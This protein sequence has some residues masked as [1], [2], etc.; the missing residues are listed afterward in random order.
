MKSD[1]NLLYKRREKKYSGKKLASFLIVVLFFAGSLYAGIAIPSQ[2]LASAKLELA[3]L[4]GE[5]VTSSFTDQELSERTVYSTSL[6]E[7]LED[8]TTLSSTKSDITAYLDAIE[9]SLP[10]QANLT[11]LSLSGDRMNLIGVALNDTVVATFCLKLIE[12]GVFEDVY[13][14]STTALDYS[15]QTSFTL[16]ATL[17][18]SLNSESLI[19]DT[20]QDDTSSEEVAE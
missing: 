9:Q 20:E 5:L 19:Q 4:E 6:S 15:Y 13:I 10:I 14:S 2:A 7:Q 8:L 1:I 11:S 18:T 17:P 12:T 3:E 16:S